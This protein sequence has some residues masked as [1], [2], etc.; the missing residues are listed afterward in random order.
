MDARHI[1]PTIRHLDEQGRRFEQVTQNL[2]S[3]A[4]VSGT[5]GTNAGGKR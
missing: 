1:R 5:T 2:L 3:A 4:R